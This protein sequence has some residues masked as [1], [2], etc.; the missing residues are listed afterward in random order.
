MNPMRLLVLPKVSNECKVQKDI[1]IAIIVPFR[2]GGLHRWISTTVAITCSSS[3]TDTRKRV[4]TSLKRAA[5]GT[6]ISSSRA[7]NQ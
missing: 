4:D 3:R 6:D 2:A 1:E 7:T 5:F